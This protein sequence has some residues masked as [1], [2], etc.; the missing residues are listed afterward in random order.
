MVANG[1]ARSGERVLIEQGI[2][3]RRPSK[4]FVRAARDGERITDVHVGGQSVQLMR[5]EILL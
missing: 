4:L 1:V 3:A 5:G 2:E